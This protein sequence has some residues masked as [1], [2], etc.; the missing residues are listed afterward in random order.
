LKSWLAV[1]RGDKCEL[2]STPFKFAPKYADNTPDNLPLY[3][4]I[5][6]VIHR[7][8]GKWLPFALRAAIAIVLWICVLPLAT[9]YLYQGWIHGPSSVVSRWKWELVTTD[10]VAGG[11]VAGSIIISFLSLMSLADVLRVHLQQ[12]AP[13]EIPIADEPLNVANGEEED[14]DFDADIFPYEAAFAE[15][16]GDGIDEFQNNNNFHRIN[17]EVEDEDEDENDHFLHNNMLNLAEEEENDDLVNIQAARNPIDAPPL[18]MNPQQQ[19]NPPPPEFIPPAADRND[20]ANDRF[21]PQ[22]EPM[23]PVEDQDDGMDIHVAIDELLGLRGPLSGLIRNLL[24]L[25]AFNTIYLGLFA[26]FPH[27]IGQRAYKRMLNS[28]QLLNLVTS[29]PTLSFNDISFSFMIESLRAESERRNPILQLPDLASITLGY[30]TLAALVFLSRTNAS[31]VLHVY[32]NG[33]FSSIASL[34]YSNTKSEVYSSRENAEAFDRQQ[35]LA[36]GNLHFEPPDTGGE[37][38][39]VRMLTKL[40]DFLDGFASIVKVGLVLFVKMLFLPLFLGIWLD[41]A[42]LSLFGTSIRER[43]IYAGKDLFGAI[44]I[45]WVFG[46]T[47]M[48]MV[49]VSVLQ[50]R[51]VVHP[52]LLAKIIRPQEP[53]PDLLGNILQ[54][55][56]FTHTRRMFLSLTIYVALLLVYVW[57][58]AQILAS[59]GAVDYLPF[60]RPKVYHFF[61][62][63]FQS[64]IELLL[65]HMSML[66]LLEKY[67]VIRVT[68]KVTKN[69]TCVKCL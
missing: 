31:I 1:T 45:H 51:E 4:V 28:E 57:F 33:I 12:P 49:T 55:T 38:L 62:P 9:A 16:T 7:A 52:D 54:E 48:L 40:K 67:K 13:R 37:E 8:G 29:F 5:A 25:L 3:E 39:G 42:T 44:L 60:F 27:A 2:C 65:F 47:F 26:C 69:A 22:F 32:K 68:S 17:F 20:N 50:L 24:W 56:G 15:N 46:I 34:I 11:I 14:D 66:A 30:L 41:F 18:E 21:E 23:A 53:Q 35:F 43:I 36:Q 59:T 63:E 64:P 61:L 58:P 10:M 19:L 6:G